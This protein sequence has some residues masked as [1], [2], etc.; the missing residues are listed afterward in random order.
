MTS[1]VSFTSAVR[2][3]RAGNS[4]WNA[5]MTYRGARTWANLRALLGEMLNFASEVNAAAPTLAPAV[6]GVL[7]AAASALRATVQQ[8][9]F[10]F[11]HLRLT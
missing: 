3:Y 5:W 10:D 7:I 1:G 2:V 8:L 11:S 9:Q 4:L 6:A